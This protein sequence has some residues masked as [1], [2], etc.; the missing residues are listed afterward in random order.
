[1]CYYLPL[2]PWALK[3]LY[4]YCADYFYNFNLTHAYL[5]R[6]L[7]YINASNDSECYYNLLLISNGG[8][9]KNRDNLYETSC[10]YTHNVSSYYLLFPRPVIHYGESLKGIRYLI[11]FTQ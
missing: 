11:C 2:K 4:Y 6:A 10:I 9:K 1:M 5:T 3:Y 8:I 7:L